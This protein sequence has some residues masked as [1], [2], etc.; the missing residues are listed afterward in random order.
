LGVNLRIIGGFIFGVAIIL[1]LILPSPL[2]IDWWLKLLFILGGIGVIIE[3][4]YNLYKLPNFKEIEVKPG[5][6]ILRRRNGEEVIPQIHQIGILIRHRGKV[7]GRYASPVKLISISGEVHGETSPPITI[8]GPG[9]KCFRLS[10]KKLVALRD[11][12]K[13]YFGDKVE[14][15][16]VRFR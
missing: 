6:L 9:H 11:D 8:G 1:A 13:R 5:R 12:L 10:T 4:V 2:P 15:R 7:W 16:K 14:E 3:A